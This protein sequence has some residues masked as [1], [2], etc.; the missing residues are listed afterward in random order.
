MR[1]RRL[2][3]LLA[4]VLAVVLH[5]GVLL[6]IRQRDVQRRFTPTERRP[7]EVAL[8]AP[9]PPEPPPPEPPRPEPPPAP[10]PPAPPPPS[11]PPPPTR[12]SAPPPSSTSTATPPPTSTAPVEAPPVTTPAPDSDA[13]SLLRLPAGPSSIDAVLGGRGPLGQSRDSLASALDLRVDGPM[14]DSAAAAKKATRAL[15]TDLADDAVS[16]GLAND[17]FRTLRHKVETAWQP[18]VKQLNDGGERT[19][20]LGMMKSLVDDRAAW[21]EMWLAYMDLAKQYANGVPP[22]LEPQRIERLRE[23]MRSRQGAFRVQAIGEVKLTQ[24]P[25]GKI[26]LLE[27][28]LPSGHPG[29]D[30]GIRDAIGQAVLAMAEPPPARLHHGRSFSSWWRLRATWTMVPP[31]AFFTGAAFDVTPKGFAVDVPFEIKLKTNVMLLRTDG[32]TGI[33]VDASATGE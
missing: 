18:A 12:T 3:E 17:Y 29:I 33:D 9:P 8:I 1:R 32:R 19:T 4:T 10:P 7:V 20:Q 13:P 24:D 27:F 30:D 25:E 6:H 11:R 16:A 21:G 26:L 31:T 23:L 2:R 22:R 15:Q 14:R 28:T 5:V